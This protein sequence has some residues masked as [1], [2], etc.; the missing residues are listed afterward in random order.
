[1]RNKISKWR[2]L[3]ERIRENN[4]I[5]ITRIY[6]YISLL[7]FT[8]VKS[9]K[10]LVKRPPVLFSRHLIIYY[11]E[12]ICINAGNMPSAFRHSTRGWYFM[13]TNSLSSEKV[14][15]TALF[16]T[17]FT[18]RVITIQPILLREWSFVI[19]QVKYFVGRN[20]YQNTLIYV[21]IHKNEH[22]HTQNFPLYLTREFVKFLNWLFD[23]KCDLF[24][25]VFSNKS[26]TSWFT[27]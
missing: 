7:L 3:T 23:K 14:F 6:I 21:Y 13:H 5:N 8:M 1:M 11:N 26:L 27:N 19:S 15:S 12:S 2:T 20:I 24:P 25:T 22:I 16:H 17:I 18:D 4:K 9:L 10:R